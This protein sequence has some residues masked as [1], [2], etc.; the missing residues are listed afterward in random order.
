MESKRKSMD[1]PPKKA[2]KSLI[3]KIIAWIHLW[4]SLVS[5][6]ILIFVCIT[7]TVIVY[8]DEIMEWSAGNARYVQEIKKERLSVEQLVANLRQEF[9]D[10]RNPGYMVSY[11]D[12]KRSVRFNMFSKELGLRMVYVDPYTGKVLKDDGTI[13]FFYITAHLHNSLLLGKTGAWVVDIAT[14]IFLIELITGLVLWWPAK[15]TKSTRDASFKVKWKAKFKRLNY[16][17]HNVIGF[18][19]LSI[20][21]ILTVTGM[22]IAFKPFAKFTIEA[23]GGSA[24]HDWEAQLPAFDASKRPSDINRTISELFAAHPDKKEAQLETFKIDSAGTLGLRLARTIGLK[25][26]DDAHVFFVDRYSGKP[27]AAPKE[28]KMHEVVENWYWSL[29]MGTWM[30]QVG[31]LATFIG[32]LVSTSLPITGF[33]IWWGRRRKKKS[34]VDDIKTKVSISTPLRSYKP[35]MMK[36]ANN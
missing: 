34:N 20:C 5:A 10:R 8:C 6:V 3:S 27:V 18:Y 22:I 32:G 7:G 15:W 30:G 19:A 24:S 21:L 14:I 12:P 26:A 4:P 35:K 13:Y 33:L 28:A 16:D 11:K 2:G 1:A 23:F 31:K 29:H 36:Q 25:S 9:P 17:L